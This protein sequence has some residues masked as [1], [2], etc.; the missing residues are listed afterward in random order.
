MH[1]LYKHE[2]N[3]HNVIIRIFHY[4]DSGMHSLVRQLADSSSFGGRKLT[5]VLGKSCGVIL[6]YH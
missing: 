6:L 3:K 4:L 5:Q 1:I 2:F